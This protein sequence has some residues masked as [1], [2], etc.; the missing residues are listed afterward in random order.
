MQAGGPT[1]ATIAA[2]RQTLAERRAEAI[3]AFRADRNPGRLFARLA[4]AADDSLRALWERCGCG[5]TAMLAAVGGYGRGEL[6]PHSDID[7]LIV[8]PSDAD[9]GSGGV[10]AFVGACWDVG[11]AIS[12]GV[13]TPDECLAEALADITVQ[14]SLL[15]ARWLA[16]DR[17]VFRTLNTRLDAQRDPAAFFTAKLLEMRQR[18]VKYEDTPYSLEPNAKENPGGLRD[19]HVVRWTARAAGFGHT[20]RELARRGLATTEEVSA[21]RRNERMLQS[22]RAMLHIIAG[23][24]EDRLVFDLQAQVARAFGFSSGSER[25][26]SEELMQR[27]YWAAKTVTQMTSILLQN[28]EGALHP[29]PDAEPEP[30]DHEFRNRLGL[31][32]AND[33]TLFERDPAAILRAFLALE[34]HPE[35][36]GMTAPALRAIWHARTRLDAAFRRRPENRALFLRLLQQPRGVTRVL[37]RMNQWSV[38]GRYLP[39]FRRIVGRMQHDLFHVYTVDQ[40]ILMVVRN[41]RRFAM[42]EHAHEYPLCSQLMAGM[43]AP[44][45]LTIA[46]LFHDIAKGRGGDH[47]SLGCRDAIRFCRAHGLERA[48]TELIGFLVE[49]HLTMSSVAQKQDLSDPEVV[50]RFAQLVGSEER[51]TAL[52]LLTVADIRGTSPKV[53]NAWKAKLLQD[54]YHGARRVLA[55]EAPG[56]DAILD[57]LREEARRLLNLYAIAPDSYAR[58]WAQLDVGYFLRTDPA[59]IAWHTRVLHRHVD[60]PTPV[61]RTRLSSIGEGFQVVVYLPDRPETFARICGFFDSRNLSILDARVHTTRHGYALDSFVVIEPGG[62]GH[63]RDILP[64]IEDELGRRLVSDSPLPAPVRGRI[65]RRSR[66]FP[67]APS[68]ELRPD[69]RGQHYLLAVTANDR[70]GLLY[71]I[72]QVLARH[73]VNL[74]TARVTTLGERVEDMFLID[75]PALAKA[76]EQISLETEL[77]AALQA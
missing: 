61:V 7:L 58:F 34:L 69:E 4:D 70:T 8:P 73:G 43:P 11:L 39:A 36:T 13:R 53:W 15:E 33:P 59:D 21:L 71:G 30:I 12:H 17:R 66:Y 63:Y 28:L 35:L 55:G 37:R 50:R 40:H 60:T 3:A 67:I 49:H 77:L 76:R 38:L 9:G 22:V 64:L 20:W 1:Q 54:L 26:A 16:G 52:Y 29:Q 62:A 2:I 44:W 24:R 65:S 47:S 48:D 6:Y 5:R 75:G 68:V 31:L 41:L 14:T 19:L 25:R 27:Y 56:R 46:A 74:H 57:H 45:R 10:E 51:L 23:R 32:E 18:H 72:A 42:D